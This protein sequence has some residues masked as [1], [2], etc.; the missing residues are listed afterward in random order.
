MRLVLILIWPC[1]NLRLKIIEGTNNFGKDKLR[2]PLCRH[3]RLRRARRVCLRR[4]S[5][6]SNQFQTA[7]PCYQS[8]LWIRREFPAL[9]LPVSW[10]MNW[11]WSSSNL[12]SIRVRWVQVRI[13]EWMD[14]FIRIAECL[15]EYLSEKKEDSEKTKDHSD[16]WSD[17]WELLTEL[18]S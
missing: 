5:S 16:D 6:L 12:V 1:S 13:D 10:S 18:N 2:D 7:S 17:C 3:P 9:S 15:F 11:L 4:S 8:N 14:S